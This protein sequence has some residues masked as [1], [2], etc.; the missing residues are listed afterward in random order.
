MRVFALVCCLVPLP[1]CAGPTPAPSPR[2]IPNHVWSVSPEFLTRDLATA[3][4]YAGYR[5]R[6]ALPAETYLVSK[7]GELAIPAQMPGVSSLIRLR[8]LGD[9]PADNKRSLTLVGICRDPTQDGVWRTHRADFYVVVDE[10]VITD[11]LGPSGGAQ[12]P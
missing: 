2:E 10:C 3:K 4:L 9:T 11:V 5:V 12:E 7:P 8:C 6:L 1:G